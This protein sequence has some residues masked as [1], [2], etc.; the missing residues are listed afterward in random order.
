MI[1]LIDARDTTVHQ[2]IRST[3]GDMTAAKVHSQSNRRK[4]VRT[5]CPVPAS[6]R[7]RRVWPTTDASTLAGSGCVGLRK[8]PEAFGPEP[9]IEPGKNDRPNREGDDQL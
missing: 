7:W 5:R 3:A 9:A 6:Y 8:H 2:R 1:S 4:G